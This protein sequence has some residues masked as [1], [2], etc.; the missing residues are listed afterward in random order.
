MQGYV[1]FLEIENVPLT[2]DDLEN[3]PYYDDDC[4]GNLN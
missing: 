4:E 3:K 2:V 1:F